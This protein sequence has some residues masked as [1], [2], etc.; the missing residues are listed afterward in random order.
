V[1]CQSGNG[2]IIGKAR[3]LLDVVDYCE[4][5]GRQGRKIPELQKDLE[6]VIAKFGRLNGCMAVKSVSSERFF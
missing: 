2:Q 3:C 6:Q 4:G 5:E 1:I